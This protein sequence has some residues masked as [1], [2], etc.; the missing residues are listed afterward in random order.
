MG[1]A[2]GEEDEGGVAVSEGGVAVSEGGELQ[3]APE[4]GDHCFEWF[5]GDIEDVRPGE[6]VSEDDVD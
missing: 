2:I 3:L 4:S 6:E 1:T 5:G